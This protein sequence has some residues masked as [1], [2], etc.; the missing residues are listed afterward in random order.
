[1]EITGKIIQILPEQKGKSAKGE[2]QKQDFILETQEQYPKKVCISVWNKKID[3]NNFENKNV[4]CFIDIESREFNNRWF[5]NVTAWKIESVGNSQNDEAPPQETNDFP[6][7]NEE[8]P[9][10]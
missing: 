2:W 5:T 10:F 4:K 9:P 3:I 1:M 7:D 8:E 6:W